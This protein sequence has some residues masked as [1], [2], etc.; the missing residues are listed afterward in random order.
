M[1]TRGPGGHDGTRGKLGVCQA[2]KYLERERYKKGSKKCFHGN[3]GAV[4]VVELRKTL[5]R[6]SSQNV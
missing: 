4:A 5:L 1:R 2:D 3:S 6:V